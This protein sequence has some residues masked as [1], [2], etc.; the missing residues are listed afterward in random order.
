LE[1]GKV[2]TS[3]RSENDIWKHSKN[4]RTLQGLLGLS[5]KELQERNIRAGAS[6]WLENYTGELGFGTF[7]E[8]QRVR[9]FLQ[10]V[11]RKLSRTQL[12][13]TDFMS[14]AM[15]G[16]KKATESTAKSPNQ[17]RGSPEGKASRNTIPKRD[18]ALYAAGVSFLHKN[19]PPE[20]ER[21]SEAHRLATWWARKETTDT[22]DQTLI[23]MNDNC[24]LVECFDDALNYYQVEDVLSKVQYDEVLKEIKENGRSGQIKSVQGSLDWYDQ[25][26]KSSDTSKGRKSSIDSTKAQ[27]GRKNSQMVRVASSENKGREQSSSNGSGDS[28]SRSED[29]QKYSREIGSKYLLADESGKASRELDVIDY[30]DEQAELAKHRK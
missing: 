22:G 4:P 17:T 24:Y 7:D 28:Q 6:E 3:N 23:F 20:N 27:H 11:C 13:S 15:V 14:P 26:Y 5:N 25:L 9:R 10:S 16:A 29:R 21:L 12:K 1:R 30:I 19:F 18:K 8:K 2:Q